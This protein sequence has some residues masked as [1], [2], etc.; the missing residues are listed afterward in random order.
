[1]AVGAGVVGWIMMANK[2]TL[3]TLEQFQDQVMSSIGPLS[4][5]VD[6]RTLL[7]SLV[8]LH[9]LG[10]TVAD[11]VAWCRCTEEVTPGLD[12]DKAL[13]RMDAI[14]ARYSSPTV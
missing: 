2:E 9:D 12:E 5:P 4:D 10:M 14:E 11:A 13:D 1:M 8:R 6:A 7:T 3:L